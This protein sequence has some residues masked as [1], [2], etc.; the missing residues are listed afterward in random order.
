MKQ[1][2]SINSNIVGYEDG[3]DYI[4]VYFTNGSSYRYSYSSAGSTNVE[5]MKI[6]AK[7]Q[8]GLNSYINKNCKYGYEEIN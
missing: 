8:N 6:L 5:Q 1:Y 4:D 2:N 3:E 7:S